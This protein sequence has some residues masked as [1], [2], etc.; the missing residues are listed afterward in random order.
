M[1]FYVSVSVLIMSQAIL[2]SFSLSL[3]AY[4]LIIIIFIVTMVFHLFLFIW[5]SFYII[6]MCYGLVWFCF[7]PV[8]CNMALLWMVCFCHFFVLH[9]IGFFLF[10]MY[11]A[12]DVFVCLAGY[13]CVQSIIFYYCVGFSL[14][15]LLFSEIFIG[16][17]LEVCPLFLI[18]ICVFS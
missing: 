15:L 17:G 2:H 11:V 16:Y 4:D 18:N 10:H 6:Y 1:Y 14:P 8:D 9:F 12:V 3:L 7:V 13:E 5:S